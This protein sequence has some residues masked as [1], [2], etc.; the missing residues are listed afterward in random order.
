MDQLTAYEPNPDMLHYTT[1]FIDGL[2]PVVCL[3]VAVQLPL[4]LDTAYSIALVQEEVEDDDQDTYSPPTQRP[5]SS[6]SSRH[7]SPRSAESVKFSEPVKQLPVQ[8]DKLATLKAYRKE[9][10]LCFISGEK[11][12]KDHKC[13]T[14]VQLHV[15]QEMLEFC[16]TDSSLSDDSDDDLMLLSTETQHTNAS[17]AAVRLPCQ[18]AGFDVVLL[19]DSCSSHSF[20]S[21]RL[22]PF[23]PQ[24]KPLPKQQQ[25]RVV[26][27]GHLPCN[28]I[29]RNCL[30]TT[31]GHT[32][33]TD[34]K[35]LPLR[36]YD[37]IIGMDWLSARGIMKIN[38]EHKWLSFHHAG[39]TI[40]LQGEPPVLF[41]CT[42][43]ELQLIQGNIKP[44][45][46]AKIQHLLSKYVLVFSMPTTFPP[47]RACDHHIPLMEGARPVRI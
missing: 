29:A 43:V 35:V 14:T 3:T 26:G 47:R 24:L 40:L 13:S 10:G 33:F 38:W 22:A 36:H 45:H 11:W 21:E 41:D 46:P 6:Q 44:N 42:V 7:Y 15:V 25:V 34:F 5:Q 32:F 12:G 31:K 39:T 9:K 28:F 23:L 16:G 19:L 8:D 27:G 4:D 2:K 17:I 30:W 37:G 18:L 20:I 1:R